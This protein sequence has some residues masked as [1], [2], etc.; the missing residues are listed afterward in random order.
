MCGTDSKVKIG[1][2]RLQNV[3]A[4]LVRVSVSVSN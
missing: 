4:L 2:V 1:L 3:T